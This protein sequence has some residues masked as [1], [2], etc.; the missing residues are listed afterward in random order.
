[1]TPIE[2]VIIIGVLCVIFYFGKQY[3]D[4]QKL[5]N[6]VIDNADSSKTL[7]NAANNLGDPEKPDGGADE[8]NTALKNNTT[9]QNN[10]MTAIVGEKKELEDKAMEEAKKAELAKEAELKALAYAKTQADLKDKAK[11]IADEAARKLASFNEVWTTMLQRGGSGSSSSNIS[12]GKYTTIEEIAAAC[13][14]DPSCKG[15]SMRGTPRKPWCMKSEVDLSATPAVLSDHDFYEHKARAIAIANDRA[16]TAAAAVYANAA[17]DTIWK[18]HPQRSG[19]TPKGGST[20]VSD[21]Y[22]TLET[23]ADVCSKETLCKGFSITG[24]GSNMKW[25]MRSDAIDISPTAPVV[26]DT[27]FYSHIARNMPSVATAT[28]PLTA[29]ERLAALV[30]GTSL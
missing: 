26:S 2:G 23:I 10:L 22:H 19:A 16:A 15:F 3:I 20:C 18:T 1:M 28:A 17:F 5:E 6:K 11:A 27:T 9:T 21:G 14:A 7:T 8:Y 25:C 29:A 13:I 30:N 24:T 4:S 12:C